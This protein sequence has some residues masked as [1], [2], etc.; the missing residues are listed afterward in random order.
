MLYIN[1]ITTIGYLL[2]FN[3]YINDFRYLRK[4]FYGYESQDTI[5]FKILNVKRLSCQTPGT[6]MS[7]LLNISIKLQRNNYS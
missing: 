5:Y 2:P 3:K 1:I 4:Y 6:E 7:F